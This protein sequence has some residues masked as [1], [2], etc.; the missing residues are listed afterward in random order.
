MFYLI[1][2]SIDYRRCLIEHLKSK[3]IASVFHYVPLHLSKMGMHFG[4]KPGDCPITENMSDRLLRLPLYNDL[5]EDDQKK[6]LQAVLEFK[7]Q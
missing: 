1:L 7:K 2:P 3:D 4:G 5:S 6:V